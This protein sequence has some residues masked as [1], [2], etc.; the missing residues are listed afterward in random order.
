MKAKIGK[1]LIALVAL[2]VIP[3]SAFAKKKPSGVSSA[4]GIYSFKGVHSVFVTGNNEVAVDLRRHLLKS[5][6]KYGAQ[7]CFS[8]AMSPKQADAVLDVG[9]QQVA[10]GGQGKWTTVG[11][12]TLTRQD[13]DFVWA[14]S[15]QGMVG[16]FHSGAGS[17]SNFLLD[18]LYEAA[19]CKH[20][21]EHQ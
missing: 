5:Q 12:A 10:T 14:D 17:A 19:G 6:T 8:V 20:G 11:T 7:A 13:G 15:K 4:S 2:M 21:G 9:E 18:S 16:A 1:S 3:L